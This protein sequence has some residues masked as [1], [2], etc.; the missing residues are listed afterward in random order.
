VGHLSTV[1]LILLRLIQAEAQY[2]LD[3][4]QDTRKAKYVLKEAEG[5]AQAVLDEIKRLRGYEREQRAEG[6]DDTHV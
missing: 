2:C 5:H 6:N 1:S 3:C 4:D